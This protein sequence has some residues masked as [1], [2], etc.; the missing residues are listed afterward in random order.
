MLVE[1]TQEMA[2]LINKA[3]AKASA[4]IVAEFKPEQEA[5]A[6]EFYQHLAK[7]VAVHS[8]FGDIKRRIERA[9][10]SAAGLHDFG[11]DLMGAAGARNDHTS[12]ALRD[13]VKRGYIDKAAVPACYL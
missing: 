12:Y 6:R 4:L 1:A 11:K 9:G 10:V 13:G 8:K 7:A 5:L 2:Q 3:R